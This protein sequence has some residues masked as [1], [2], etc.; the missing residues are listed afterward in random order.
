MMGKWQSE[1]ILFFLREDISLPAAYK[2]R[3][4]QWPPQSDPFFL[5][6]LIEN[7]WELRHL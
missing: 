7:P 3:G 5:D 6:H 2:A 1:F 4:S